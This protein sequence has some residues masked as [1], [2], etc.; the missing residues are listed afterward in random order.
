MSESDAFRGP[1]RFVF[2]ARYVRPDYHDGVSRFSTGLGNALSELTPITLLISDPQQLDHFPLA[3]SHIKGP[4]PESLRQ[5]ITS[6]LIRQ[7]G[8]ADVVYSPLQVFWGSSRDFALILTIHDLTYHVYRTPPENLRWTTR[9]LWRAYHLGLSFQRAN[10]NRADA[11]ATVSQ[12]SAEAIRQTGLVR[13]PLFVLPNAPSK[14]PTP[15]TLPVRDQPRNLIY[16]GTL[17]PHKNVE[18]LIDAMGMLPEWTLHILSPASASRIDRLRARLPAR[19]NVLFH[20]GVTDE[21][22]AAILSPGAVLVSA[23]LASEGFC[24][25]AVEALSVGVPCVLS[26]L[27]VMREVAGP[28]ALYFDPRSP[29]HFADVVRRM[30]EERLRMELADLG[31]E[32]VKQFTWEQSARALL[33]EASRLMDTRP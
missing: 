31:A 33:D 29:R 30:D 21:Q 28:G 6:R 2:D 16:M 24:L 13:R 17:Q 11:V 27:P 32:H 1:M 3:T 19:A 12:T 18:T 14:L 26:D 8:G 15:V 25:P 22:Y 4:P 5:P 10:L 9:L 20:R 7:S 23:S